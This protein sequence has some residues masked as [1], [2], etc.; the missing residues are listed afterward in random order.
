M[1]HER[2]LPSFETPHKGAAPQ[3]EGE[4][5]WRGREGLLR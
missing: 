5:M 1:D 3:D 4:V 2:L